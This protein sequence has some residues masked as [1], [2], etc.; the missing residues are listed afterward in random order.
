TDFDRKEVI[1]PNKNFVVERLQNW[2]LTD[3]ITRVIVRVGVAYGSDL[4][5]TRKL[6]LQ[7]ARE[8]PRVMNEPEP[9]VFFLTFGASTLDHELR[10]YVRELRDRSFAVDELNRRIDQLFRE[11]NIEIAFNQMDI[12]V[13]NLNSPAQEEVKFH[14]TTECL[15]QGNSAKKVD[16]SQDSAAL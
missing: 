4:E 15:P 1:I 8:N 2:S 11:N 6:L 12:Y 3:T 5:L 16:G 14:S 10:V 13:K 9:M 7:A